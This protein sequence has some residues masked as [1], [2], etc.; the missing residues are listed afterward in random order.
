AAVENQGAGVAAPGGDT[1]MCP[2]VLGGICGRARAVVGR[3][4]SVRRT[5]SGRCGAD[6]WG[7]GAFTG[8]LFRARGVLS[9]LFVAFTP[10]C[11]ARRTQPHPTRRAHG[12]RHDSMA[13]GANPAVAG[14]VDGT[15]GD[16][17]GT[18][19]AMGL[20]RTNVDRCFCC[21]N[22]AGGGRFGSAGG[23]SWPAPGFWGGGPGRPPPPPVPPL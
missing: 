8:G 4:W 11:P 23:P 3:R 15:G 17:P 1:C 20:V 21:R 14:F 16:D 2:V 10:G 6:G 13:T 22:L 7:A 19:A 18:L 12:R 9:V 5:A